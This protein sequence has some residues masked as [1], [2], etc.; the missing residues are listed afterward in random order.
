MWTSPLLSGGHRVCDGEHDE[1]A[2]RLQC[3]TAAG[4]SGCEAGRCHQ[5]VAEFLT[6]PP[7]GDDEVPEFFSDAWVAEALARAGLG[8]TREK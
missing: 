1:R 2:L 5:T 6:H 3:R 8:L 7:E 4:L